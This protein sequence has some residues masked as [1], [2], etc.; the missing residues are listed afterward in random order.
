MR[1][2]VICLD[3][4]INTSMSAS[5]SSYSSILFI[6]ISLISIDNG[7]DTSEL[8]KLLRKQISSICCKIYVLII[9]RIQIYIKTKKI[10]NSP[11]RSHLYKHSH[12]GGCW[13]SIYV[14]IWSLYWIASVKSIPQEL[15]KIFKE[16]MSHQNK[17]L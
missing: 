6:L 3:F 11:L 12:Y 15:V 1:R 7:L 10:N 16:N 9:Y 13:A 4:L 2:S 17:H 14:R 8:K 5:W